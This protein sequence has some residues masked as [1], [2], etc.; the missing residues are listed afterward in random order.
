MSDRTSRLIVRLID[1]VSGPA[2][3]MRASMERLKAAGLGVNTRLAGAQMAV[4][5]AMAAN[6]RKLGALRMQLVDAGAGVL[7]FAPGAFPDDPGRRRF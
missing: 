1:G 6:N 2:A 5:A 3:V 7:G 4:G